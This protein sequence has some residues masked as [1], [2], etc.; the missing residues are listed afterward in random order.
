LHGKK[1]TQFGT[2]VAG[3]APTPPCSGEY[4]VDFNKYILAYSNNFYGNLSSIWRAGCI[5]I[6][7]NK[8]SDFVGVIGRTPALD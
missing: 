8:D 5:S 2:M 6:D 7:G 3:P 1:K 4:M